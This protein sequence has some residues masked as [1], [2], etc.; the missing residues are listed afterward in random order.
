MEVRANRSRL[1][2]L[3]LHSVERVNFRCVSVRRRHRGLWQRARGLRLRQALAALGQSAAGTTKHALRHS[4][5]RARRDAWERS[6]WRLG[7]SWRA[8]SCLFI[9]LLGAL[10]H[11]GGRARRSTVVHRLPHLGID[12]RV[13]VANLTVRERPRLVHRVR[14]HLRL[15]LSNLIIVIQRLLTAAR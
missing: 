6:S 3:D 14:V 5:G 13:G 2:N 1:N 12:V 9:L 10:E 8:A 4:A 11:S 15:A 7:E